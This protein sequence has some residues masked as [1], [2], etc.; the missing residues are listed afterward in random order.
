MYAPQGPPAVFPSGLASSVIIVAAGADQPVHPGPQ[1]LLSP[2]VH[3]PG[4]GA[5]HP[6]DAGGA[7]RSPAGASDPRG[8][9]VR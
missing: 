9:K 2:G 8:G 3:G 6:A 5:V 7:H 4:H 1:A